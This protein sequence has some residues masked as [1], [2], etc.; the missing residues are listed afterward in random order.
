[1]VSLAT[2]MTWKR[3][4]PLGGVVALSGFQVVNE[5]SNNM[6]VNAVKNTPLFSYHGK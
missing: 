1:M 5:D 4:K 3:D 6:N 2:L